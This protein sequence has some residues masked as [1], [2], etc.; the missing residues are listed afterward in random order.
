MNLSAKLA[1]IASDTSCVCQLGSANA[2]G[3]LLAFVGKE[4]VN[5]AVEAA[6][7]MSLANKGMAPS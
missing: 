2:N 5:A 4:A 7:T 3:S 6:P 1:A